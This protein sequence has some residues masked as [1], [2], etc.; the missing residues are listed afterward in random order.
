M[1]IFSVAAVTCSAI[2]C[3]MSVA[4]EL[5]H[6]LETHQSATMQIMTME[7][8]NSQQ[9]QRIQKTPRCQKS[10]SCDINRILLL[11]GDWYSKQKAGSHFVQRRCM[12]HYGT[13]QCNMPHSSGDSLNNFDGSITKQ[14]TISIFK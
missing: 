5:D 3:T 2:G 14:P 7:S 10:L 11:N 6:S 4:E 12:C 1:I 13:G 9:Q 8:L